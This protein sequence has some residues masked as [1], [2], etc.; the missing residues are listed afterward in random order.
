MDDELIMIIIF[1]S[2][3]V[4]GGLILVLPVIL[5]SSIKLKPY[6]TKNP[7]KDW[8]IKATQDTASWA[9]G[10]NFDF[11]GFYTVHCGMRGFMAAWKS[12]EKPTYLCQYIIK[13]G[14]LVEIVC[15]FLT[16]FEKD[17]GLTTSNSK[18]SNVFPQPLGEYSQSFSRCSFDEL[19]RKHGEAEKYLITRG[20]TQV[21]KSSIDFEEHFI[22]SHIKENRYLWMHCYGFFLVFYLYFVRR[23]R[24][25]NKTIKEQHELGMIKL[26]NE[27]FLK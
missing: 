6:K 8:K 18:N 3:I 13:F 5:T 2:V 24:W 15:G 27:I 17:I 23:Y 21:E 16:V 26:P 25:H 7:D 11:L 4:V 20:G 14:V 22:D 1:A 9:A 10:N 12:K 19:L